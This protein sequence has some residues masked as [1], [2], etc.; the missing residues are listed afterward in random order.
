MSSSHVAKKLK[1]CG[2]GYVD[3]SLDRAKAQTHESFRDVPGCYEK[4][5]TV[6]RNIVDQSI[7]AC[8]AINA[9]KHN[10]HEILRIIEL[11]KKIETKRVIVFNF[12]PTGEDKK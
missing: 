1:E 5:L 8:V 12:I 10:L 11:A 4:I 3:V 7:T 6:I 2:V 9:T